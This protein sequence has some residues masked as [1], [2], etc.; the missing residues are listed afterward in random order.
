M[1]TAVQHLINH[2][3][4]PSVQRVAIMHY[5]MEHFT[6]P[7]V[8]T[9]Y[10]D[11]LPEIPTLSRTT[12]YNTLQLLQEHNA[13]WALSIDKRNVHYDGNLKPHAH[14]LC[15]ECGQVFDIEIN[16]HLKSHLHSYPGFKVEKV[17][18]NYFGLC[19]NCKAKQVESQN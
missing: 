19:P 5:L 15:R 13:V 9:I 4:R 8:D 10:R 6:H 2:G 14:F 18:L 7:T 1:E 3:I 16:D 11:L 17:E 12:V